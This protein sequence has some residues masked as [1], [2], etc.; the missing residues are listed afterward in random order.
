MGTIVEVHRDHEALREEWDRLADHVNGTPFHRPG[1][2]LAWCQSFATGQLRTLVVREDS[3][4]LAL[5]PM[6]EK[7]GILRSPT[8]WHTPIFG[9]LTDGPASA[10]LIARALIALRRRRVSLSFLDSQDL[11]LYAI[12]DGPAATAGPIVH[13]AMQHSPYIRTSGDRDLYFSGLPGDMRREI[14]RRR[15]RLETETGPVRLEILDG[16]TGLD[17]LLAQGFALE[18][19]GWKAKRGTAIRS[20]VET[21]QF[22]ESISRWAADRGMLRLAFLRAGEATIAF[23]LCLEHNSV[24]YL[25]KTG[26]DPGYRKFAPG[27]LMREQMINRAFDLDLTTYE[28]LGNN[29]SWKQQWTNDVRERLLIQIFAPSAPGLVDWAAYA[30]ARPLAKRVINAV[31]TRMPS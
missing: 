1:W 7:H 20:S 26:F 4:M 10:S 27:T 9:P 19:S 5:L 2:I 30:Y 12:Q 24:H 29:D 17:R 18:A 14:R 15:R 28:F 11:F 23:D 8:N 16:T 25:V 22:Y 3:R 6:I 31:R 21:L 13:R